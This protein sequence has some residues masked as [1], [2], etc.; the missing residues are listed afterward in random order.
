MAPEQLCIK[1]MHNSNIVT[2]LVRYL[3]ILKITDVYCHHMDTYFYSVP[4]PQTHTNVVYVY[5]Q[6]QLLQII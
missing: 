5:M 4:P 1:I 2:C 3:G 6:R